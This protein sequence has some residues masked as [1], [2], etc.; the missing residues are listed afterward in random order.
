MVATTLAAPLAERLRRFPRL[1]FMGSKFRLLPWIG[2]VLAPLP[3]DTALDAFSGSGCVAYLLKSMGKQVVAN[4]A[5]EFTTVVARATVENA[6][7]TLEA[8]TVAGL[9]RCR[10]PRARFIERTFR[11]IFFAP[12]DL[13][14]LDG[15]WWGIQDLPDAHQ[16]ALALAALIRACVKRQPRGVFT[17]AGDP[18]RYKD[19]RRDLRLSLRQHFA[20]QV[21]A[22]NAAVFDNGRANRARRGDVFQLDP[23]GHDL[24]YLDP[25]YVPR[26][27][28]NCYV[29]RYH[30]LEGLARYW[31]GVEILQGSRVHKIAKPYTP[32]SRRADAADAFDRLFAR[33]QGSILVLSYSSNGYPDLAV[34]VRLMR[35]YKRRVEVH[36]RAHRYHFGTHRRVARAQ[37]QEYLIVGT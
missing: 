36:Q 29:K 15:A 22:Y 37:V 23:R 35:R 12:A 5:L 9:L 13:R 24:V 30:F 27:D 18:A 16:R 4:D 20:E 26:A 32:F 33:F 6:A 2:E 21:A 19:G 17:V 3:F 28:D 14:F 8:A 34:L 31:R 25:P 7:R 10:R 11:G 1:R